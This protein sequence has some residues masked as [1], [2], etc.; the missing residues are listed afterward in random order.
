MTGAKLFPLLIYV[1]P[2]LGVSFVVC[3]SN[4]EDFI[5]FNSAC[6][7]ESDY[8]DDNLSLQELVSSS[9][10]IIKAFAGD[11]NYLRPVM[12][13]ASGVARDEQVS[14]QDPETE[15]DSYEQGGR[16]TGSGKILESFPSEKT[17]GGAGRFPAADG[18][19]HQQQ[20]AGNEEN[21]NARSSISDGDFIVRLD[22]KLVYKGDEI[23]KKLKLINWQH[24]VVIRSMTGKSRKNLRPKPPPFT[25]TSGATKS[26]SSSSTSNKNTNEAPRSRRMMHPPRALERRKEA[27]SQSSADSRS[28]YEEDGKP[29]HNGDRAKCNRSKVIAGS[30]N[31]GAVQQQV[32]EEIRTLGSEKPATQDNNDEAI[33]TSNTSN[34]NSSN[35]YQQ[36]GND[37]AADFMEENSSS[38][39]VS[40]IFG[41]LLPT[42]LIIFGTI[43]E[44]SNLQVDLFSGLLLWDPEL[45]RSVWR[46]L[47]WSEW[48]EYTACSASC[49]KGVQQRFRHCLKR[50]ESVVRE[51]AS[52]PPP[53][54]MLGKKINDRRRM[55]SSSSTTTTQATPVRHKPYVN[56]ELARKDRMMNNENVNPPPSPFT[57]ETT[58]SVEEEGKEEGVEVTGAT[59]RSS[60]QYPRQLEDNR[61]NHWKWVDNEDDS[62]DENPPRPAETVLDPPGQ[63][64]DDGED[65]PASATDLHSEIERRFNES[66][67]ANSGG[68]R[69]TDAAF[70]DASIRHP[71]RPDSTNDA[72]ALS[73]EN[74]TTTISFPGNVP[75][76]DVNDD[77]DPN[78]SHPTRSDVTMEAAKETVPESDCEGFNI[79]Q[80]NCN[81]F[82]CTDTIDLLTT[83]FGHRSMVNKMWENKLNYAVSQMETNFT[84]MLDLRHKNHRRPPLGPDQRV[85]DH[86]TNHILSLR[87]QSSENNNGNGDGS[88]SLSINFVKDGHGGLKVIQ[89]KF[90]LSEMLPVGESLLDGKWHT[91]GL[92]GR[93]GGGFVNVFIDCRWANSFVLPRGAIELPQYPVIETGHDIEFR[94]LTLVPGDKVR[95]QCNPAV[96][97]ITDNE[98][99][100]VTNYFEGIN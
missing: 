91:V 74:T 25:A 19:Y 20:Q 52:Q 57:W 78:K 58:L 99:R 50:P 6:Y 18:F 88:S 62:D 86:H 42:E 55:S 64:E 28:S 61:Q 15:E 37:S 76:G 5:V 17:A 56:I 1:W 71:L 3:V 87:S 69:S 43:D 93:N 94:Q 11:G 31:K 89:E 73:S 26:S 70:M 72:K 95:S 40:D 84:L 60:I 59:K 85:E 79:E 21:G 36:K 24:Y 29:H 27:V 67:N 2:F 23:F 45:E 38:S 83:R 81:M 65:T 12:V 41:E 10:V 77:Y 90:G 39:S 44:S 22:P 4:I 82:E 96:I 46:E 8:V 35:K 63:L 49:G 14:A 7:Y 92:S 32:H 16:S 68:E 80:R 30:I 97:P 53:S 98:N 33:H 75:E 66:T 9:D 13:A 51:R 34:S 54:P 47:G 48:S 100:Q